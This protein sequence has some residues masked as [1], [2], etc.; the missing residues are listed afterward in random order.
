MRWKS[1]NKDIADVRIV[2]NGAGAAG[3]AVADLYVALGAQHENIIM[4]DSTRRHLRRAA[5][6]A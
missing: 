2:I 4:C 6:R 1:S 5:S 3:I